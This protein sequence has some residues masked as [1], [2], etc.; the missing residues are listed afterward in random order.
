HAIVALK[1]LGPQAPRTLGL[2]GV[3]TM[4]ENCLRCL[5]QLYR[6]DEIVC[7]SARPETRTAFARKWSEKLRIPVRPLD[8]IEE[9]VRRSDI[10]IGATTLTEVVSREHWVKPGA[11]F[12]SLARRAVAPA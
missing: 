7:T 12:V 2:V 11:T 3:G 5:T 8:T 10:A 9:V 1:L 6:F 4:G